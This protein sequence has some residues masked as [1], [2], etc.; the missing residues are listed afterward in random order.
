MLGG[1]PAN[2]QWIRDQSIEGAVAVGVVAGHHEPLACPVLDEAPAVERCRGDHSGSRDVK[3]AGEP[4]G[5]QAP[6]P[7]AVEPFRFFG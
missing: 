4:G 5:L 2:R 1:V 7:A 6:D 3:G